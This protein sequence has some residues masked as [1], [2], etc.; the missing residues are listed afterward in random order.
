MEALLRVATLID[1]TAERSRGDRPGRELRSIEHE[2]EERLIEVVPAEPAHP[3]RRQDLVPTLAHANERGVER[4]ASEIVDDDVL[5]PLR[6]RVSVAMGVLEACRRRLVDERARREAGAA[7]RV[8]RHEARGRVRVRRHRDHGAEP[9][10][11]RLPDLRGEVRSLEDRV[12]DRLE[13]ARDEV[14]ERQRQRPDARGG[15]RHGVRIGQE[16]LERP[17]DGGLVGRHRQRLEAESKLT[18]SLRDDGGKPVARIARLV[19]EAEHRVVPPIGASDDGAR[20]SEIDAEL[21]DCPWPRWI[22][23]P[24]ARQRKILMIPV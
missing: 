4:A 18:A 20:G 3:G 22:L 23:A 8:E 1:E 13:K 12:P 15:A 21:H 16:P 9:V 19:Q 5:A 14:A 11:P 24:L 17:N 6:E 7:E 2:L 10:R